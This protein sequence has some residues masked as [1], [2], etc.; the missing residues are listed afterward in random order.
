MQEWVSECQRLKIDLRG[1]EG[2]EALAKVTGIPIQR[3][4][5]A[6]TP[7]SRVSF[8]D[9]LVQFIVGTNQVFNF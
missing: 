9:G 2:G 3:Q 1:K 6:R 4:V 5:E 7:F 8:L